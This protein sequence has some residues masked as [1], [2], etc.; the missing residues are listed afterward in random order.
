MDPTT[1]SASEITIISTEFERR[2]GEKGIFD[3]AISDV[4]L[5]ILQV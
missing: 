4:V 5:K 1:A 2:P 3:G